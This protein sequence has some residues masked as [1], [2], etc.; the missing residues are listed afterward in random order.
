MKSV[1]Y[2]HF[3]RIFEYARPF[4]GYSLT[5]ETDIPEKKVL[6]ISANQIDETACC[7]GTLIK[8]VKN[9]GTLETVF[10][11]YDNTER[12]KESEKA[13]SA[14]GSKMNHFLQL[15]PGSLAGS[16][17]FE[18]NL[19][20]VFA[21]TRPEVVFVPFFIDSNPDNTAVSRT[22]VKIKNKLKFGFIVYAY[23]ASCV[24]LPNCLFDISAQWEEKKKAIECYK[25]RLAVKDYK[26]SADGLNG[27]WGIAQKTPV[28]RAELFLKATFHEYAALTKITFGTF[29]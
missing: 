25:S 3:L 29:G 27:Y 14:V 20:S 22:L 6:L 4:A 26:K 10:C 2:R 5:E 12:M 19:A 13:L 16:G 1:K 21:K 23:F 11:T 18:K 28:E 24:C 15:K 8:H 9:G 17:L 7:A